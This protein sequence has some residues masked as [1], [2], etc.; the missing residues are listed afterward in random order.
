MSDVR[1]VV[2]CTNFDENKLRSFVYK[3]GAEGKYLVMNEDTYNRLK[4]TTTYNEP[5]FT[6]KHFLGYSTYIGF[7]IAICNKLGFGVVEIV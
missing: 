2:D 7:P 3:N 5:M 1:N 6:P 4:I